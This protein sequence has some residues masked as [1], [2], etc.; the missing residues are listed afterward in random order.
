[1][2][3]IYDQFIRDAIQGNW[4]LSY[5]QVLD[6]VQFRALGA[7]IMSFFVVVL[8][9][10]PVIAWLR[11]KKIGDAGLSDAAALAAAAGSKKDVPTMG[12]V[13]IVG[14]IVLSTILW[15]DLSNHYVLFAMVVAI[16]LAVLGGFDDWLKLTAA[17]R[18]GASRQGLYAW[19][20]LVFQLGLG[21]LIGYFAYSHGN[22]EAP[23]DLAHVLNLPFQKTFESSDGPVSPNLIYLS[24]GAYMLLS[25]LMIAGLSNAVNITDGMD[26]LAA[27]ISAAVGLGV[28]VMAVVAGT[29]AWS[30]YLLVPYVAGSDEL[31]VVAGA[32]A[33]SCL[34]FLWF[35][36]LP[37]SVFMGDT[38]SLALGG[39][40]GYFAVVV[41]QELL[42][43]FMCIVF[44]AEIASVVIQVTVFKLTKGKRVF[45]CAPYHHHLHILGWR[46]GQVV[47]R[48]WII[49]IL[50]VV[51]ALATIKLR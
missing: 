20:K 22:T 25:T 14:A 34:G 43:L 32:L 8:A 21:A 3:T 17:Q 13:L 19:E 33:G 51:T 9:G 16:W 49:S 29:R 42:V 26:G 41:R 11:R 45:K 28:L 27:G 46:E 47:A 37:A 38:G 44:I 2:Y 5:L 15:C 48:F 4:L 24:L 40:I 35:N 30:Q 6:Q 39:L 50:L 36:C 1:M 7:A 18:P 31:A 23:G 12:G 10:K